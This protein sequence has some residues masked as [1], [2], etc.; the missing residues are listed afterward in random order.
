MIRSSDSGILAQ[1]LSGFS[2]DRVAAPRPVMEGVSVI[3]PK[4]LDD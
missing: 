2:G 3:A 1:Q 4:K